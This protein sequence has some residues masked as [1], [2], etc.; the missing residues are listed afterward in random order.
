MYTKPKML[1]LWLPTSFGKSVHYEVLSFVCLT[2]ELGTGRGQLC[3]YLVSLAVGVTY[4][5][6]FL[7][8]EC[9]L[10]CC[11]SFFSFVCILLSNILSVYFCTWT[12]Y[13]NITILRKY[14]ENGRASASNRY[15]AVSLLPRGLG[16]RLR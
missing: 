16:T 5:C 7:R 13:V 6:Q 4:D 9:T 8:L 14:S 3:R 10:F 2:I 11:S 1:F 15:Q 12:I